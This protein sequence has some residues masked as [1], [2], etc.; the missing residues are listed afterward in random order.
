MIINEA[1]DKVVEEVDS[2]HNSF[3]STFIP[4]ASQCSEFGVVKLVASKA[5]LFFEN[6]KSVEFFP[7]RTTAID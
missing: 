4:V 6:A 5:K 7:M 1:Q 3:L 2:Y